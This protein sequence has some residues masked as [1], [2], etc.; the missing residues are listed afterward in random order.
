MTLWSEEAN[1]ALIRNMVWRGLCCPQS[2]SMANGNWLISGQIISSFESVEM[3]QIFSNIIDELTYVKWFQQINWK[4]RT[5]AKSDFQYQDQEPVP[6]DFQ[7]FDE[8]LLQDRKHLFQWVV[9]GC[10]DHE[11]ES[12][13]E[14][15]RF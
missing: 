9:G 11:T 15:T 14:E 2:S 7:Y 4:G 8:K 3:F 10:S 1:Y 12:S 13:N 6:A 5:P